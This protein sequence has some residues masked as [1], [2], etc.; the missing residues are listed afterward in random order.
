M[1]KISASKTEEIRKVIVSLRGFR[2][3]GP[4]DD[5]DQITNVTLGYRYLLIQLQRLASP[6]LS[7]ASSSHLNSLAI[8]VDHLYQAFEVHAELNSLI[9]EIED[10]LDQD[11]EPGTQS[12]KKNH[13]HPIPVP[14]CSI[15][16]DVLGET[17]YSHRKL[18]TMFYEAGAQ[19]DVPE[20]N[21]V[22]KCQTWLKRLHTEVDNPLTV[23]GKLIE[24]FMEVDVER[25]TT[26]DVDRQ[27]ISQVL[28]KF[29]LSYRQG[30]IIFG[31]GSASP[32]RSLQLQLRDRNIPAIDDEFARCLEN[33]DSDP[34]AAVTAASS[35]LES[36]F[37]VYIEDNGLDLPSKQT[38]TPLWRVVSKHLGVEPS[39][40]EDED[41][42]KVLSG[43]TSIVDGIGSLRTHTG[44]AHG[45]SRR[46]YRLQP[47]HARLTVHASHT[48]VGF[49]LDTWDAR[50]IDT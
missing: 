46:P 44:S 35:I 24:E 45:R 3:C 23:L 42:K 37:K 2:F 41:L 18:E 17:I 49:L 43:L 20:G 6:L 47:R 9:I 11:I 48:L 36:L 8:E 28:A 13:I 27:S 5:P 14:V 12:T 40:V 15:I 26:Q 4:G 33:V 39:V 32:T 30:G 7:K 10:A 21:C 31:Q 19:D 50:T 29:G 25:Y 16:G 38:I 34:R 1:K 22:V